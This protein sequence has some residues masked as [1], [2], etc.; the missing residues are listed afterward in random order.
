MVQCCLPTNCQDCLSVSNSKWY[1]VVYL[2]TVKTVSPS[3]TASGTMLF[4]HLLSRLSLSLQ[5]QVVQCCLPTNCQDC[6]SVSNSKW[7]NVVYLLTVKTVSRSPQQVVQCCLPT[8]C[9][10]CL[11][12]SNSKWYNVVYLLTVKTVS[13]SP[14]QVVQC[15]LPTNCQDCLSVSNSMWYNVDDPLTVKTVSR[16]P[17]QVV[18]C[19]LPTNCQ[20]CLS[21]SNSKWYNVVDPLTVKTV[22]RSPQQVVQCCLPTNCQDCLSVSNSKWYNVVDPLTVKTVS[23]SP[24]ASGTMLFTHL[25]SR[26]SLGLQQQVV[27]C[28]LP[29][30]CQDCLSVSNSKWYNVVY[31]LTVKTDSRSPTASGT[32][33]FTH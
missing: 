8:N 11:S 28:C 33:L 19:C 31:L 4:T 18:Q 16:S 27:Q 6:L 3:P 23:R 30:N 20:D 10:D 24:T 17:Q 9:Q 13:R 2:L 15:C 14:Q 1:N 22:S 7:Y 26:L 29:T 5:Q 25:L 32:M 21:V 12:V